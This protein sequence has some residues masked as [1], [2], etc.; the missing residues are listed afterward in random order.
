MYITSC[1]QFLMLGAANGLLLLLASISTATTISFTQIT[2]NGT[3]SPVDQITAE[4]SDAGS[5]QVLFK[6]INAAGGSSIASRI[7]EVYWE[8]LLGLLS[9]GPIVD[10]TN[11]SM[12]VNLG[13]IP[14]TP[15]NLPSGNNVGFSAI[16]SAGRLQSAANG[17]D[18][19]E[20]AAFKFDADHSAVVTALA[21]G[22]MRLGMHVISIGIGGNSESLVSD[23]V[24]EPRTILFA[25]TAIVVSLGYTHTRQMKHT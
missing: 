17:V 16:L 11:T 14:A 5:G 21:S 13:K 15:G 18:P 1:K 7:S 8:D 10:V 19:G 25:F 24:P 6:F 12:G 4:V 22:Q 9:N 20:M 3:E 23:P 2:S